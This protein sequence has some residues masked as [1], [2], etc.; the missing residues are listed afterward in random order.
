[1]I[2]TVLVSDPQRMTALRDGLPLPG[3]VLRYSS[4]NLA[5]VFESI[6]ANQP[7][8][9]VLDSG[10]LQTPAGHGFVERVHQLS[11]P[12]VVLQSAVF[13][14]GHWTMTSLDHEPPAPP[15]APS[16][17]IVAVT[18]GLETRRAPR[19]LAQNIAQAIADGSSIE[20]VD[21]SFLGAQIISQPIMKPHQKI[22]VGLPDATGTISVTASVA[23]SIFEKPAQAPAPHFRVGM[24]FNDATREKLED[25]CKRHC[26]PDPLPVRR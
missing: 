15:V 11:I 26:S 8:L 24:E 23:W 12:K 10:F 20:V 7:G 2:L 3:R 4:S 21:L 14:R 6:R 9:I 5:S 13:E 22:K 17:R 18:A 25:Y 1:M 19:F 16:E